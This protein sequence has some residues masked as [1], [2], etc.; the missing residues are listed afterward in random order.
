MSHS[1]KVTVDSGH[2]GKHTAILEADS[3]SRNSVA[4]HGRS[5]AV[6]VD[7]PEDLSVV[8]ETLNALYPGAVT[9]SVQLTGRVSKTEA[10]LLPL[11]EERN[12]NY[13]Q[14][15]RERIAA[16][17]LAKDDSSPDGFF[18]HCYRPEFEDVL[19][20]PDDFQ[21]RVQQAFSTHDAYQLSFLL[22]SMPE[23]W[24][25]GFM[26]EEHLDLD[27]RL[28]PVSC[29]RVTHQSLRELDEHIHNP[30]IGF[31]G[32]IGLHDANGLHLFSSE[33][34][35]PETPF[36]I[37]S[38][39]KM[40][41]QMLV[42]QLVQK[43]IISKEILEPIELDPL[44]LERLPESVQNHLKE[45]RPTLH[46]LMLHRGGLGE[47]L[48]N[49]ID[50]IDLA[51]RSGQAPPRMERPE[52]F[53][54]FAEDAVY[55]TDKDHYSNLGYLLI[56]LS[57][58]HLTK[59]PFDVLLREHV[60]IPAGISCFSSQKP[61]G[62]RVNPDDP[63]APHL[64]GSPAGGYWSTVTDLCRFG[65]WMSKLCKDP[66]FGALLTTYGEEFYKRGEIYHDG[67]IPSS[68][69]CLAVYPNCD[70]TVAIL[71]DQNPGAPELNDDIRFNMLI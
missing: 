9:S 71:S 18:R 7:R 60:L 28:N 29:S 2:L 5:Y 33:G 64:C 55:P 15:L 31:S 40:F 3:P 43:G 32:V 22:D 25:M 41:T 39:G 58:Q 1:F 62:A 14:D 49:Y 16:A 57:L 66:I 23:W 8:L 6:R 34:I 12:Q 46:Q 50:A 21:S 4:F 69:V 45:Q 68:S 52:D 53:L 48:D 59:T 67:L 11:W 44:V 26:H 38:L 30:V 20:L 36:A 27:S 42:L 35:N 51:I 47:Y 65:V 61:E 10:R 54:G 13:L 17:Y 24:L 19:N 56:G 70:I 37:H 63:L